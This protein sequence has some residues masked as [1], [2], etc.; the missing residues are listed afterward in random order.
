MKQAVKY[1]VGDEIVFTP[2]D[3]PRSCR[4]T[5]VVIRRMTL[6][7]SPKW[8]PESG[9]AARTTNGESSGLDCLVR[10]NRGKAR[11]V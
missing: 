8:I 6:Q 1:E 11:A 3:A 5:G 7:C 9:F 4:T 10:K 2:Y